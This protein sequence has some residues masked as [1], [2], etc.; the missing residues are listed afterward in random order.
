MISG[1]DW[2]LN[3]INAHQP[4]GKEF[5]IHFHLF[6][7]DNF[8]LERTSIDMWGLLPILFVQMVWFSLP[9]LPDISS[10]SS[11]ENLPFFCKFQLIP[12]LRKVH[13]PCLYLNVWG[14]DTWGKSLVIMLNFLFVMLS[15]CFNRNPEAAIV[16]R[17]VL[18]SLPPTC[19]LVN[20][21]TC[22]SQQPTFNCPICPSSQPPSQPPRPMW[23]TPPILPFN[24]CTPV[25]T[26][27]REIN[28]CQR[29]IILAF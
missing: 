29:I 23:Y 17:L 26:N 25:A 19:Q 9:I 8:S 2:S 22:S 1:K 20:S 4:S 18:Q 16:I 14:S 11:N 21:L 6:V 28:V 15:V 13:D 27:E 12:E 7:F 24:H 5:L 10:W 3:S